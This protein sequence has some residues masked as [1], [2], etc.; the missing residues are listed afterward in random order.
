MNIFREAHFTFS[1]DRYIKVGSAA[2][3]KDF[4]VRRFLI[5]LRAAAR[6][7]NRLSPL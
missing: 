1:S 7:T 2:R 3:I 5:I 6:S 4:V